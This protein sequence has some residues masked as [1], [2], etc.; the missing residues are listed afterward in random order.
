MT[1]VSRC[2]EDTT[3]DRAR[4][5]VHLPPADCR[6]RGRTGAGC[7]AVDGAT[8]KRRNVS[9]DV[10][11][12]FTDPAMPTGVFA[13]PNPQE[14]CAVAGGY[15]Y[16][17][18]TVTAGAFHPY[19]AEACGRGA[20]IARTRPATVRRLSFDRG[21]GAARPCLGIG[22]AELGGCSHHRHRW[23]CAARHR[24]ELDDGPRGGLLARS[25]HRA[26]PGWWLHSAAKEK[27]LSAASPCF[28]RRV[29]SSAP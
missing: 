1:G 29:C 25:A 8:G 26:T 5:A 20:A 23:R 18:D 27:K 12:G 21:V 10:R 19:R 4:T 9:G 11:S 24:V 6:R 28:N 16:V 3:T 13:C 17:I 2:P 14:M 7:A 15:A 22:A